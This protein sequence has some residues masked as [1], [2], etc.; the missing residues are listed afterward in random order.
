ML[1]K[2]KL[3]RR[4]VKQVHKEVIVKCL[5]S[6]HD[7]RDNLKEFVGAHFSGVQGNLMFNINGISNV[8]AGYQEH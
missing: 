8:K 7:I 5:S 3:R 4:E 2:T 1:E 6:L